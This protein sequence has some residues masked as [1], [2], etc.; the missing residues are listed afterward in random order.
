MQLGKIEIQRIVE[1]EVPFMTPADMFPDALPDDIEKH[2]H[3]LE[4]A[5]LDPASGKLIIAI[6]TYV[7]RTPRHTILVDTCVGCDKTNNYF[8]QWH[9]RSDRTWY[10]R[11]LDSGIDPASVDYVFCT[12]LHGDHCG[13]NTRLVDGRFVPTFPN[14]KYVIAEKEI[15]HSEATGH[16]AYTESVLPCI[17]TGQ[18]IAANGDFVL[19]DHVWLEA[20]PGHTPGHVSVHL[21]SGPHRAVLT[22]DLIH[23][24]I[25]CLYPHWRYWIDYDAQQ[26]IE[27]RKRFLETHC[28]EQSLVLTA[29]FPSPSAGYIRQA[30]DTY[31]FSFLDIDW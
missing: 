11:L 15:R 31:R 17:E 23:C 9:Q 22:G 2:R 24:P 20:T 25:Q 18:V 4:P 27:T 14:A 29:H 7:I 1:M 30:N 19:D 13:W 12:H 8:P 21:Q 26:A 10:K 5:C 6:Q 28:A 16:P 3:W